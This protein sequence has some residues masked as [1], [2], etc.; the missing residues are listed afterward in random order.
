[1]KGRKKEHL[2]ISIN[3]N[4]QCSHNYWDDV[5]LS[6]NALPEID[7]QEVDSTWKEFGKEMKAPIIIAGMTGGFK[8]SEII[9]ES[10]AQIAE[11]YQ[12]GMGVGSQRAGLEDEKIVKSYSIINDYDI[13][14]KI[15]NVGAPQLLEWKAHVEMAEKAV[16]MIHADV[17]AIHLN[18]LQESIQVEGDRIARGCLQKITEVASSLSTPVIVKET[19]AGISYDVAKKLLDTDIAGIDVG[20]M[21]GT[22]FAAIEAF[23]AKKKGDKIQEELGHIFWDWGIPTPY[24]LIEVA[25]AC[26]ES[27]LVIIATGGIRNGFD[28]AKALALGADAVGIAS[29]FITS[30]SA[31]E[32][33]ELCMRSLKTALFLTGCKNI[34]ELKDVDVWIE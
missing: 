7:M 24:S 11:K 19:G 2:E 9:N 26:Q 5:L 28:A 14:L 30:S 8:E 25:E 16:D 22:S 12:I 33:M 1:M 34:K 32:K 29:A 17:L 13:P 15:A 6:H 10:L 3:E 31:E 27:G 4:V 20:G 21:G 18:F 23:R